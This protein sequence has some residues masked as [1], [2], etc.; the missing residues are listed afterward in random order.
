MIYQ[1]HSKISPAK[2][3]FFKAFL[4][5]F[6]VIEVKRFIF[7][8][9]APLQYKLR[10]ESIQSSFVALSSNLE[11]LSS[12]LLP[13]ASELLRV[14]FEAAKSLQSWLKNYRQPC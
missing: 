7:C 11:I 2:I 8:L 6:A 3:D 12:A 14:Y 9:P 5:N 1:K 10:C 13:I 4:F